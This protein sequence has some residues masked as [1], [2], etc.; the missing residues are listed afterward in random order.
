[1]KILYSLSFSA[2]IALFAST[3]IMYTSCSGR[4]PN[5]EAPA[6]LDV[7]DYSGQ[8]AGILPCADCEGIAYRLALNT[9]YSYRER[10]YYQGKSTEAFENQGTFSIRPDGIV[11]LEKS[12]KGM[13]LF[14][15]NDYGL[16]MLDIE[17][18]E[19]TGALAD[20]Y[21][22]RPLHRDPAG[23]P[24][25]EGDGLLM[26]LLG[27]GVDFYAR[28]NEPFWALDIDFDKV[29]KFTT[30]SG[31]A[32]NTP[33]LDAVQGQGAQEIRYEG[34]TEAGKIIIT[35]S[36][37]ECIDNMSGASFT[38]AVTVEHRQGNET[39]YTR[40]TGCGRF[41]ADPRLASR[42]DLIQLA[43]MPYD[44]SGF[45]K[46]APYLEFDLAQGRL[47]GT[48]GCNRIMG[49]AQAMANT[50]V[51]GALASTMMACPKSEPYIG[52]LSD[53]KVTYRIEGNN[54]LITDSKGVEAV[55]RRADL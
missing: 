42:W 20:R 50:I 10:L 39:E 27:E 17:G 3:I 29:F 14:R 21:Q 7:S 55:F 49:S 28:G 53:Q 26:K 34:E 52:G 36:A 47:G 15:K 40:Y 11:V 43:G 30:M 9:D 6:D 51:F 5:A 33:P 16:L 13:S 41:V 4:R 48:D 18:N 25:S 8:Y 24:Q 46:D 32:I 2:S 23:A 38:H 35:L 19:I 1:M 54:L 12:E 31:A 37:G 45:M 22:L 44:S